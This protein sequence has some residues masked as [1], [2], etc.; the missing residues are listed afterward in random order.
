MYVL[1]DALEIWNTFSIP[2]SNLKYQ[3]ILVLVWMHLSIIS[4]LIVFLLDWNDL[5]N[6]QGY[7]CNNNICVFFSLLLLLKLALFQKILGFSSCLQI[8]GQNYCPGTIFWKVG[9][10]FSV[11]EQILIPSEIYP[12]LYKLVYLTAKN[13]WSKPSSVDRFSENFD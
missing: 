6:I 4:N 8:V 1:I 13:I 7:I 10:W 12:P 3:S 9:Q 5:I 11:W 2:K